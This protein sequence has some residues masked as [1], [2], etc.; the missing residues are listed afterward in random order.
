MGGR[1][2]TVLR[3]GQGR[4]GSGRQRRVRHPRARH[5]DSGD[6]GHPPRGRVA[7]ASRSDGESRDS[8]HPHGARPDD[9][10]TDGAARLPPGD[11]RRP[12]THCRSGSDSGGRDDAGVGARRGG[13][14]LHDARRGSDSTVVCPRRRTHVADTSVPWRRGRGHDGRG[15]GSRRAQRVGPPGRSVRRRRRHGAAADTTQR[16]VPL[17]GNGERTGASELR[18]RARRRR[19]VGV[20]TTRVRQ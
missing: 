13:G 7:G 14:V 17:G 15:D 9:D 12:G 20:D 1:G 11:G 2:D 19:G 8:T 18:V 16:V 3:R 5:R 10:Q 4:F 6:D